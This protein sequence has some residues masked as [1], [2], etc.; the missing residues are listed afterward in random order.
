MRSYL[1]ALFGILLLSGPSIQAQPQTVDVRKLSLDKTR[2]WTSPSFSPD[3]KRIYL[4]TSGFNG[5]WE[6]TLASQSIRQITADRRSGF[7]FTISSGGKQLA[8]R[9]SATDPKTRERL[10]EIVLVDLASRRS[11][12]L[13]SGETVSTPTFVN[14][15]VVYTVGSR[16]KNLP[17]QSNAQH[18]SIIGIEKTKIALNRNG[19]KVL[20]DPLKGGSYVWPSL[21]PDGRSILAYDMEKG[22]FICDLDGKVLS[23]LG[24]RDA[25]GWT[26]D[27]RWIVFMRDVDDGHN[28][29]SSDIWCISADGKTL[30]PLTATESVIELYPACSPTENK[31][32]CCSLSGEV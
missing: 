15:R 10:Q 14:D 20:L 11:R 6:Y 27:G 5:I 18:T 19:R 3:G 12:V 16:T 31:L 21:S 28:I 17:F 8:Y 26:R 4:T 23:R 25:P 2:E 7:G 30:A 29:T 24:R 32:V 22:T 1:I 9:R 13:E